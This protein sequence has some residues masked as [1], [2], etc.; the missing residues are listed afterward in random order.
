MT[1]VKVSEETYT[2][3]DEGATVKLTTDALATVYLDEW[4]SGKLLL[5]VEG[6]DDQ[7]RSAIV[8][9]SELRRA[10]RHFEVREFDL[11]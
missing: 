3:H 1:D 5:T 8:D 10:I 7:I 9:Y 11:G 2:L 4:S 6:S